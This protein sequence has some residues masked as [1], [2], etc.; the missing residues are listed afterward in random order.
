MLNRKVRVIR[1]ICV[2]VRLGTGAEGDPI[3]DGIEFW[4]MNGNLLFTTDAEEILT[5][6]YIPR[7]KAE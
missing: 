6:D 4:D 7:T 2:P 1:V 5:S 3:R